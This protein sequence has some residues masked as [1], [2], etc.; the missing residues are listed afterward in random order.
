MHAILTHRL[1]KWGDWTGVE[2]GGV[3]LLEYLYR[4]L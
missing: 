4:G 3:W 2:A 1:R